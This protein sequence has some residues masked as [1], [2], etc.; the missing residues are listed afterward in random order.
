MSED[1]ADRRPPL[2]IDA[3]GYLDVPG[4]DLAAF[5]HTGLRMALWPKPAG[6]GGVLLLRGGIIDDPAY[7][8]EMLAL[9]LSAEGLLHL[10]NDL[11]L[12]VCEILDAPAAPARQR[13]PLPGDVANVLLAAVH[14][15][16]SYQHG[17]SARDLAAGVAETIDQTLERFGIPRTAVPIDIASVI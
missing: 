15:L 5:V 8:P 3:D 16:R 4:T 12:L 6:S 10:Q 7:D 1:Q 17:N 14:A 9:S 11:N 2:I 13:P